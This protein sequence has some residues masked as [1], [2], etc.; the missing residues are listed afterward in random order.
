MVILLVGGFL[1]KL[2]TKSFFSL[3]A[4]DSLIWSELRKVHDLSEFLCANEPL[5]LICFYAG[6]LPNCFSSGILLI[7][8]PFF[9]FPTSELNEGLCIT[10]SVYRINAFVRLDIS[11]KLS[12][13]LRFYYYLVSVFDDASFIMC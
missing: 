1:D 4:T 6:Y 12:T 8:D 11:L 2:S 3:S 7:A 13:D 10:L 9:Y 5:Y